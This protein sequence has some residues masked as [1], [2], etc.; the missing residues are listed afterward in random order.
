MW[1][2]NSSIGRKFVMSISGFFLILFLTF[3][4]TMNFVAVLSL[5]WYDAIAH[6][7]GTNPVVQVAVP[8]LALGFIIHIIYAIMLTLQ[9]RKAR[10]TNRY[11]ITGK[12]EVTW[13]SKNMFVIGIII[14]GIL[15][16]HLT[17][18]WA[19]MQLLEWTGK[20]S[21]EA[22][23]LILAVFSNPIVVIGYLIWLVAVWFH[24]THGFWSAFQTIGW[25]NEIWYQRLKIIG[26]IVATIISLMFAI[27]P[28]Y[29]YFCTTP[30]LG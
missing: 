7:L 24:L 5:E 14:L 20:P 4:A 19:K 1:L 6:F 12:S 28:I 3:H 15:F 16:W 26:I 9:N 29:Y 23:E 2:C 18:F 13:A 25:N 17:Q 21:A 30:L 22:S 11:A 8:V 10:G 27:V